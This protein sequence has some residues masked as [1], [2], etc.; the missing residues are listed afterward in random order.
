MNKLAPVVA[1]L[2]LLTGVACTKERTI[3]TSSEVRERTSDSTRVAEAPASQ[4]QPEA[5]RSTQVETEKSTTRT[6]NAD[7]S[8]S[9]QVEHEKKSTT[10]MAPAEDREAQKGTAPEGTVLSE[11]HAQKTTK[12]IQ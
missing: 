11:E 10:T 9:V 6:L 2:L 5:N 4:P 1:T 3:Q 12:V 8:G 7:P